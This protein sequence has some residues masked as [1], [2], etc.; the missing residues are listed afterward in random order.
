MLKIA[1]CDDERIFISKI[2]ELIKETLCENGISEY[3]IDDFTS[4]I[5][6]CELKDG[7]SEYQ[8]VFLDINMDKL[9]GLETAEH[10]RKYDENIFIVF[11]TA[12]VDY[13]MEGYKLDAIRFILKDMLAEMLPECIEAII[14]R[15]R[16]RTGRI[17]MDFLEGRKEIF[18]DNVWYIESRKHKVYFQLWKHSNEQLSLYGKL[19][20]M[21]INLKEYSFL[22]IHKSYLINIKYIEDISPYKALVGEGKT[23]PIPREKFKKVKDLFLEYRGDLI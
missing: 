19:D 20:D 14:K 7:I 22:R 13:A 8:V 12:F 2:T 23:L 5:D 10:I 3:Q 11:I 18:V 1:V 16:L 6:L 15:L 21:E 4:G 17:T 9:S